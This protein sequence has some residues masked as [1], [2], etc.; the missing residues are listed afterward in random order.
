MAFQRVSGGFISVLICFRG[1]PERFY[2]VHGRF[3]EFQE[4]VAA[5]QI[6][7]KSSKSFKWFQGILRGSRVV[8]EGFRSVSWSLMGY[9]G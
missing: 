2:T 1:I 6:F 4:V 9:E 8:P 7:L 3:R 5:F